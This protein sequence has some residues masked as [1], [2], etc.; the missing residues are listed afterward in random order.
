MAYLIFIKWLAAHIGALTLILLAAGGAGQLLLQRIPFHS[1]FERAVYSLMTGFGIWSTFIFCLGGFHLIYREVLWP[2]TVAAAVPASISLIK[3]TSKLSFSKLKPADLRTGLLFAS[4]LLTTAI[5][6]MIGIKAFYPPTQWD[7][8]SNHLVIA[9]EYLVQ[10]RL[11]AVPGTPNQVI[12]ALN[13]LLFTWGMALL[14]DIVAQLIEFTFFLLTAAGI[15]AYFLRLNLPFHGIAASLIWIGNPLLHWIGV[16]GYIDV[17]LAA[18]V[19]FGLQAL[20]RYDSERD[21]KWLYL[22]IALLAMAAG[23]KL[24]GAFFILLALA[25]AA[26]LTLNGAMKFNSIARCCILALVIMTPWYGFIVYHTGNPLYPLFGQFNRG[27]F[28]ILESASAPGDKYFFESAG[29]PK[30]ISGLIRLPFYQAFHQEIFFKDNNLGYLPVFGFWPLLLLLSIWKKP[31]R[32]WSFWIFAYTM[33]WF[34]SASYLRYWLPVLP[35]IAIGLCEGASLITA[36]IKLSDKMLRAFALLPALAVLLSIAAVIIRYH[37]RILHLSEKLPP[38]DL[39]SREK[40]LAD[41]GFN[42]VLFI[43]KNSAPGDRVFLVDASYF[44][45]YCNRKVIGN[46]GGSRFNK[47]S[48]IIEW[49]TRTPDKSELRIL[50]PEWLLLRREKKLPE[51]ARIFSEDGPQYEVVYKDSICYLFRLKPE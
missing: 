44:N 21:V 25:Y 33:F 43:N 27:E 8:I 22:S 48:G 20:F 30:T 6:L 5:A 42:S 1:H 37:G 15:Y 39:T 14:D 51:N 18:Y 34:A 17:C 46:S 38:T 45:Y 7:A 23:V 31:L 41:R 50:K 40:Y 10:H 11:V 29:L 24:T 16:S 4:I 2:L 19:M 36:K 35:L 9:R 3:H 12:H 26:L 47:T 32:W 28:K 13:H 49:V